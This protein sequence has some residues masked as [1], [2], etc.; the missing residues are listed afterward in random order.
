LKKGDIIIK[1]NRKSLPR[2]NPQ[3]KLR[4]LIARAKYNKKIPIEIVRAQKRMKV[5]V[6]WERKKKKKY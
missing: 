1:F 2:D 5:Y 3:R 4:K 6:M